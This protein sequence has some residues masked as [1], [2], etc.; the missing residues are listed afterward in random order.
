MCATS[1]GGPWASHH[2]VWRTQ[3]ACRSQRLPL[4]PVPGVSLPLTR[5]V[6]VC[7]CRAKNARK[8]EPVSEAVAAKL[9]AFYK[10]HNEELYRLLGRDLGWDTPKG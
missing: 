4:L 5:H 2:T 3:S 6:Y 9:R 10:P 7:V 1:C 8:Y